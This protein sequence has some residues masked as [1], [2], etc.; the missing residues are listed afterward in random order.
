MTGSQDLLR[1]RLLE[2]III[3]VQLAFERSLA[4]ESADKHNE[5]LDRARRSF[6]NDPYF[7]ALVTK[8]LNQIMQDIFLKVGVFAGKPV[9]LHKVDDW[10]IYLRREDLP[11]LPTHDD[12]IEIDDKPHRVTGVCV[13]MIS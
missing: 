9:R 10:T 8:T 3:A 2:T 12:T 11:H 13:E 1:E 4:T 5:L 6:L 7:R